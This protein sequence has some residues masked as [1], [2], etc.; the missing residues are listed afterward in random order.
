MSPPLWFANSLSYCLQVILLVVVG[1]ALPVLFRLRAPRVLLAYWQGLLAICLVLPLLQPWKALAVVSSLPDGTV[2]ISFQGAA[3]IPPDLRSLLYPFIGGVLI[4]GIVVR[5]GWLALGLAR[6][7]AIRRGAQP[8]DPLPDG[9]R[10]L[11]LR[12]RV[13]PAW[14]LSPGIESPATFGLRP[15]SILLPERFPTMNEAFQRAIAGHEMLHVVRRDWIQNLAEELI[16]T[17]FWFH[18]AVAWV[19]NRIRLSRE[20]TVDAEVV[21]LIGAR[22]PY[23]SALL[24]IAGGN[25]GPALGAAPAFLKERQLAYRIEMLVK[26]VTMSKARLYLSLTAIVGLSTLAGVVGVWAFPLRAPAQAA[27][28]SQPAEKVTDSATIQPV[29]RV[30]PVYPLEAKKA[31][32]EGKVRLR[33]TINKDGTVMDIEVLSSGHGPG[34]GSGLSGGVDGGIEG[35]VEGG[36]SGGVSG[37]V[38]G[39]VYAVGNGVS[40]PEPI[41][42]PEPPYTKEAK[43]AKLQGTVVLSIVI[44][45]DGAVTDAKV[46]QG[47]DKGL[48]QNAVDTVKTWKFKPA[49]KGGRPVACRVMVEVSFRVF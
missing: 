35:G 2:S 8:F 45:V 48:T 1:S 33:V 39:G 30:R 15:P 43:A 46:V 41:Y 19:V 38:E 9:V 11:Q 3:A 23:L 21:R 49:M 17:I 37:G 22:K 32:I 24:E 34:K 31:G 18:P 29:T 36:E 16:L 26:E 5:L 28:G 6:L 27:A 42:K 20:Q 40:S 13:S 12:L 14:Y 25:P 10:E 47:F 4:A 44:G 7:R